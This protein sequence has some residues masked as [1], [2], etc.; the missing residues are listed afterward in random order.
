MSIIIK[1][2]KMPESCCE[3]PCCDSVDLDCRI[4]CDKVPWDIKDER[5]PVWCPLIEIPPHG[6]LIDA[7]AL[8]AH[9]VAVH[10][11]WKD[12]PELYKTIIPIVEDELIVT[13]FPTM[14]DAE[15]GE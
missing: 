11:K 2:M 8:F 5:R 14:I 12:N 15:E 7:D 4:T 9:V 10:K 13:C 3:C 1:N 6:R